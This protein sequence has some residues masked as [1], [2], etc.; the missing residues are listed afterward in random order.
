MFLLKIGFIN[1]VTKNIMNIWS[2]LMISS[3]ISVSIE[4][5]F[6]D[7][8]R[9]VVLVWDQFNLE[10]STAILKHWNFNMIMEWSPC[11]P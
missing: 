4:F 11:L 3:K 2:I 8:P 10:N 6:E 1:F 7:E 9:L 5:D